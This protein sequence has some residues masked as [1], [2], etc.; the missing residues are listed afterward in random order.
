MPR[1]TGEQRLMPKSLVTGAAGFAGRHLVKALLDAG[2]EVH[3][4]DNIVEFTGGIDPA[5]GWPLFDPRDYPNFVFERDDCRSWFLRNGDTDFDYAFHLAAVVGGRLM[6]ETQPLAVAQDLSIDAAF[7]Q[8]A[9]T[10]RPKKS[11]YLSSSAAYPVKYQ[12]RE[13]YRLLTEDMISF[14]VDVGLPD[15]TYG[16][17]KLTGEYLALL[18]HERH[19]LESAVY[20]PF[21]GY[22]EDQDAAYPFPSICKRVIEHRTR[23][24]MA[25]W[26]SGHQMRDFIHID[27][28]VAGILATM[29]LLNDGKGIN[30]ST[31]KFTSFI[32]FARLAAREL[33]VDIEVHGTSTMP[34]GVFARAGDTAR[35]KQLGFTA[36]TPFE[37]GVRNALRYFGA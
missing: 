32:D 15:L 37:I 7:W 5:A 10:A 13:G 2:H 16:W 18:A 17:A 36:V 34:E 23:S 27:D 20:R 6:M 12:R 26:G 14:D 1:Q 4:V 9:K 30:L 11:V 29:D 19:G 24:S 31:G 28:C 25:V 35:Q 8:W 21:S 33:G 22:G 3:A